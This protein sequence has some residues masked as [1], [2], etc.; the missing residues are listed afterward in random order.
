MFVVLTIALIV[1]NAQCFASC[2]AKPDG[3]GT[4][5][6]QHSSSKSGKCIQQH[7]FTAS[8]AHIPALAPGS[9]AVLADDL[10]L[11]NSTAAIFGQKHDPSPP[12]RD[13]ASA[14]IPIR[15]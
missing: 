2:L 9:V 4:Q 5:C 11:Q 14:P 10:I 7:D 3:A 6:P 1:A 8:A 13:P 15:I 12:S